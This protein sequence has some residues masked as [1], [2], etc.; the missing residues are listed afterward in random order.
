[1]WERRRKL[2]PAEPTELCPTE[3]RERERERWREPQC[4][5]RPKKVGQKEEAMPR[6]AYRVMPRGTECS[7][8]SALSPLSMDKAA[9]AERLVPTH[10]EEAMSRG[11]YRV[12]PRGTK[13]SHPS[14]WPERLV[15]T[16]KGTKAFWT[17]PCW[18]GGRAD[19]HTRYDRRAA[20]PRPPRTAAPDRHT[21]TPTT[22][23]HDQSTNR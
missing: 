16:H 4:E 8:P 5:I 20:P 18:T 19:E 1:M 6:R 11:T 23:L 2:C 13:C 12:M 9:T 3:Q 17:N 7:H 15:P 10:K 14:T 21:L 22:P